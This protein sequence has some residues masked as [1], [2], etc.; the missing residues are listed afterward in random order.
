MNYYYISFIFMRI[1]TIYLYNFEIY[2]PK[3]V[4]VCVG[5]EFGLFWEV[6]SSVLEDE[7][8]VREGRSLVLEFGYVRRFVD[9]HKSSGISRFGHAT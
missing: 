9:E 3:C 1:Y 2:R 5:S 4:L 6:R 8:K 7:L